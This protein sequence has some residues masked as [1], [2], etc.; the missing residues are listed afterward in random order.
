MTT[1]VLSLTKQ[2]VRIPSVTG[3]TAEAKK[4]L[5]LIEKELAGFNKKIFVSNGYTS[6]LF[7]NTQEIPKKFHLLLN[8]HVDVVPAESS[9]FEPKEKDGK[10]YGRGTYDTKAG[11][12]GMVLVFKELGGKVTYPLGLQIVTD[13]EASGIYGTKY[14]IEKSVRA[15]FV[16]CADST[17]FEINHQSKGVYWIKVTSFGVPA[18]GAYP[19]LGK[20]A[21]EAMNLFL[22]KL[23]QAFPTPKKEVWETT[24]N[25]AKIETSNT[26]V[27]MVPKDCSAYFDIRYIAK[28]KDTILE[29]IKSLLPSDFKFEILENESVQDTSEKNEYVVLLQNAYKKIIGKT[30]K[31]RFAHGASDIR[32]FNQAGIDG[33]VLSPKGSNHHADNEWIDI[34][35]LEEY[36]QVLKEFLLSL[37]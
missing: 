31:M 19:W 35:N 14:Q 26:T 10:L 23:F 25:L 37:H 1:S 21:I 30:A 20:N 12:A 2:L 34:K 16:L 22:E 27:N 4:A 11:A 7:Y 5:D 36:Y 9:E 29:K 18:H 6:Y 24:I 17:N 15:D 13:E 33:V 32:F 3:N 28:D 8:T